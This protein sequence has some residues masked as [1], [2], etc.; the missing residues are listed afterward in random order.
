[1]DR[2]EPTYFVERKAPVKNH[3]HPSAIVS[4]K[5]RLGSGN[6]IGPF[7]VIEDDVEIGNDNHLHAGAVLRSGTRMG[8][9]NRLHE[10]AVV[11][12]E[13]QDLGFDSG[14]ATYAS[15]GDG[16]VLRESVTVH[17]STREGDATVLGDHNY[18]M[19][20]VHVGHDCRLEDRIIVAPGAALGG[21]VSIGQR[22]FI[23]GGVMIHQFAR[24]G[25]VAM[26]GGNAKITQDVL[27]YMI[28]DGVPGQV[29]GLNVV[30]LK[31]AG[32][33]SEDLRQLKKAYQA[34]FR[35]GLALDAVVEKL[36][37]LD[38]EHASHLADFIEAS[39]RGFH[40]AHR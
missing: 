7:A 36:R 15:I 29:Y 34:I 8:D 13:P 5:A 14:L 12:G 27:P 6:H 30:G 9:G 16:N 24:V 33:K 32:F 26:I 18:L 22:A 40:R 20:Q 39:R 37:G 17:R 19:A 11:G 21:F 3:I 23:S 38:S 28:T 4:D 25:R 35:S 2:R 1:M 31:R 10:Y